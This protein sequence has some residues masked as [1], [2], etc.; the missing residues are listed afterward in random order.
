MQKI[1]RTFS[2]L[3]TMLMI[4]SLLPALSA[5]EE[6]YIGADGVYLVEYYAGG[7]QGTT[8][9]YYNNDYV[10]LRNSTTE[11][12][13]LTGWSLQ[14][15][16]SSAVSCGT[17]AVYVLSG[18]IKANSYYLIIGSGG[19]NVS[20]D[21][22]IGANCEFSNLNISTST[23]KLALVKNSTPLSNL[24][25]ENI[26]T[27]SDIA[28]F[29]GTKGA[30]TQ[31]HL[32]TD[33]APVPTATRCVTR[34]AYTNDNAAD[35]KQ[36]ST[37]EYPILKA[38]ATLGG[39]GG[40]SVA[41][42][43]AIVGW[44]FGVKGIDTEIPTADSAYTQEMNMGQQVH[45]NGTITGGKFYSRGSTTI[46]G[47]SYTT[48]AYGATNWHYENESED[49][50]K[51]FYFSFKTENYKNLAITF[52]AQSSKAGPKYLQVQVKIDGVWMDV[53]GARLTLDTA[54]SGKTMGPIAIN[55]PIWDSAEIIDMRIL[56]VG[57]ESCEEHSEGDEITSTGSLR[58]DDLFI[59]GTPMA[60][61]EVLQDAPGVVTASP[62]P[63]EGS[64]C[65]GTL[66]TLSCETQAATIFYQAG[67]GEYQQIANGSQITIYNGA[68]ITAYGYIESAYGGEV[69]VFDYTIDNSGE[70]MGAC[71]GTGPVVIQEIYGQGGN[72]GSLY[73]TDYIVLRN[74]SEETVSLDGWSLL[75]AS[76]NADFS[77]TQALTK[78]YTFGTGVTIRPHGY[79]LI[80][81]SA[82]VSQVGAYDLQDVDVVAYTE[83]SGSGNYLTLSS[84]GGKLALVKNA[85]VCSG[86]NDP[87]LVDMIG[88]GSPNDY[89]GNGPAPGSSDVLYCI[90]R[91]NDVEEGE[92][93]DPFGGSYTGDN[94]IDF[95][96]AWP[97]PK[98]SMSAG[99]AE[100]YI[101][102]ITSPQSE[103]L[104]GGTAIELECATEGA[105]IYYTTDGGVT[106]SEYTTPIT[107]DQDTLTIRAYATRT[108]NGVTIRGDYYDFSF[109]FLAADGSYT[110][111]QARV[112]QEGTEVTVT[113]TVTFLETNSYGTITTFTMQDETAG[114][115][116]R[117]YANNLEKVEIG[118]I[119]TITG[120]RSSYRGL[121]QIINP[122]VVGSPI[123]SKM[124]TPIEATASQLIDYE[125]AEAH[126]S[127]YVVVRSARMDTINYNEGY[128]GTPPATAIIDDT[129]VV[130][131]HYIPSLDEIV[132][133]DIV[134]VYAVLTQNAQDLITYAD[135]Y[136]LRIANQSWITLIERP[137]EQ[138]DEANIAAWDQ[139]TGSGTNQMLA[140][141]GEYAWRSVVSNG[142]AAGNTYE[143]GTSKSSSNCKG[144]NA[145]GR[146]LQ[147][148]FSTLG[149][150]NVHISA[151]LRSSGAG[152]RNFI[153]QYSFD[154]VT[155]TDIEGSNFSVV[156]NSVNDSL[157]QLLNRYMLPEALWNQETV[158]LRWVLTDNMRADGTGSI[159]SVGSL[160][161]TAVHIS[162][163]ELPS[164]LK[165]V[166]DPASGEVAL[167]SEVALLCVAED[168]TI[169]YRRY[170]APVYEEGEEEGDLVDR[171]EDNWTAF[172][173][174]SGVVLNELPYTLQAYAESATEGEGRVFTFN[175]TQ[176]KCAPIR[177]TAYTGALKAD[178]DVV[179]STATSGAT[180][181][182]A[183]TYN[184]GTA[185]ANTVHTTSA[186]SYTMSFSEEQFPVRVEAYASKDGYLDSETL[187]IDFTLKQTGGE[188]LYFGQ[189]HSHTT[190]SDGVGSIDDAYNYAKNNASNVDFL[191]VTDH[192]HYLDSRSN[193]GTLDGKN[194]GTTTTYIDE[195]GDTVTTTKWDLGRL[196]AEK[197]TDSTFVAD[198][199]YEMTWSGQ[200][201][202]INTY[203]TDGFV[204]RNDG[205]Y[206]VSG[207]TGLVNYYELLTQ[208][209]QSISMFNHPGTTFGTFDDYAYYTEEYDQVITMIEVG[210]GEGAIGSG[211]YWP[212]Y[213]QYTRALDKGW[214]LAPANNQD[215]HKGRWGDANTARDVIW[216]NDFTKNGVLQAMREMRM[217][218]TEDNNL[219][220][221]YF[222]N[223]EPL[224]TI[225]DAQPESLEFDIS[226]YDPDASDKTFTLSIIANNGITV[227]TE[228]GVITGN[229][230]K[231]FN[232]TLEPTYSY[233]YV[234][235]DQS[236][237][238]I[239]VT[240]P[241]WIGE[242]MKVG[243]QSLTMSADYAV[244]GEPLELT[245]VTYNNE[246]VDF[247]IGK[248]SYSIDGGSLI[249]EKNESV[250]LKGG[251]EHTDKISFTPSTAGA[252]TVIAAV[253]GTI[254]G[255]EY[256]FTASLE[257]NV[258][259]PTDILNIAI[260]ASHDNYY[261]SGS[262]AGYYTQLEKIAKSFNGRVTLIQ[263][264]ISEAAL[265][266][267][268]LLI[269]T[270]PYA[271]WSNNGSAYTA[272]ELAAITAY[273]NDGGNLLITG[274]SDRG[275]SST[276][277][278]SMLNEIIEAVGSDT[279][280]RTD[281]VIDLSH[282]SGSSYSV[283]FDSDDNYLYSNRLMA[284]VQAQ[285]TKNF[286]YH[287][288]SSVDAD[289]SASV[290]VRG[291]ST[292]MGTPYSNL[293]TDS[294]YLPL[295]ENNATV[296]G[297]DT[298]L[299]TYEKLSG[300]G[301]MV[302]S[303]MTFFNDYQIPESDY[304]AE[305]QDV[306]YYLTRNIIMSA[307]T[308]TDISEVRQSQVGRWYAVEGTVTT[309]ASG[310]DVNTAFFDSIYIQD[311]TGGIN[312][313]PVS[314]DYAI[315]QKVWACGFVGS[316]QG[317]YQL[318]DVQIYTV[319]SS[320][321][322]IEPTYTTTY[323]S[324]Q[325]ENQGKLIYIE[326]EVES[327]SLNEGAVEYIMVNDG[328]G[329]SRVFIDGYIYCDCQDHDKTA[330]G[331]DMS[332]LKK[333]SKVK[334]IGI[335]STGM[336][337][338]EDGIDQLL[339]RIRIRNRAEITEIESF[340]PGTPPTSPTPTPTPPP[341]SPTPTPTPPP[342]SPTPTP[343]PPP[344]GIL[345]GDAD[346]NG[347]VSSADA[348]AILRYVVMLADLTEQGLINGDVDG[349]AGVD[350]SDA[351]CILRWVVELIH[352]FPVEEN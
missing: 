321:N 267:V 285:S 16:T 326:G 30:S 86:S 173:P 197:Y 119:V 80:Q 342:E 238:N 292:T 52:W 9:N 3:L 183:L 53:P 43:T 57:R 271:G 144:W 289:E 17:D 337:P 11:D 13:D 97:N 192:S 147:F 228:S 194:R 133:G 223:D 273:C 128:G 279:R 191:I 113:G 251:S 212:S 96:L 31:L 235:V 245:S 301:F 39:D 287:S 304:V 278:N 213:E 172:D 184:F 258:L 41:A 127:M 23:N 241:I 165:I 106:Y 263:N 199:G 262:Y 196:T 211:G 178:K 349:E 67:S 24:T 190:L 28:D 276:G 206:T 348:A 63:S 302:V 314:G 320:I 177:S 351:A 82:G 188:Q 334:I 93:A 132:K 102:P 339:P 47:T 346:C 45:F 264:G 307:V 338:D 62:D 76:Q 179:L 169:Y 168:A 108:I 116:V 281:T 153:M 229:E 36:A 8:A 123:L 185:E 134:D 135:G 298:A 284:E 159:S 87:N 81:C 32:G 233:Y 222:I 77:K 193:L 12:V 249:E 315:G 217:Y 2:I 118:K 95:K 237:G 239:A 226:V 21:I 51:G 195:N 69:S 92:E 277:A 208:Y 291:T 202:H 227:H 328:S 163:D 203:A 297:T 299:V 332:W 231:T 242:V 64:V 60:E 61:G 293:D 244:V 83:S 59:S 216:T 56:R 306:N 54:D 214:H 327:V 246:S 344:S 309:N 15:L 33:G 126:E 22:P 29:I 162:G 104:T 141:S 324:M 280:L 255:N 170:I 243:V 5:A 275:D 100:E 261:I 300:G 296:S 335:A 305:Q 333:G 247:N 345:Y 50:G 117:G 10:I 142:D 174:L 20:Q 139:G 176:A 175:Y 115:T 204:S 283:T 72:K 316:Y 94:S 221:T 250:V 129:G 120:T 34:T 248:I 207:G 122:E 167:N 26:P 352:I 103:T 91:T 131:I 101:A 148:E 230:A 138:V 308:T 25:N 19:S 111:E 313:F 265:S 312:L 323:R 73:T 218:A 121:E 181:K 65:A 187:I 318:N 124:P 350:S 27:N 18:T 201:G 260:D 282:S 42:D 171:T 150:T 269:I 224:G 252:I 49:D 180:I 79:L 225:F 270:A 220:V 303:G 37:G 71:V 234:R 85:N 130:N 35:W 266:N 272:A 58:I 112:L 268:D 84:G 46:G 157:K 6:N 322:P 66:V 160:N 14:Y 240:A 109:I 48:Y 290:V 200:Y 74:I 347:D 70:E 4:F 310:H 329:V 90:T 146:Y 75:Y 317:D 182:I 186:D 210:N 209:P 145:E 156:S 140:S 44:T 205:T 256:T 215:N 198:F 340:T 257:I 164:T 331:H 236:D 253:T 88:W 158:Y 105:V 98:N 125:W 99:N 114:I 7:G 232:F 330:T 107:T 149:F 274:K 68:P 319:D 189:I 341:E 254:D 40:V 1:K 78:T 311:A 152:P 166:A 38:L 336:H 288:G 154:G 161:F 343:T 55:L 295:D 110:I 137:V 151:K 143:F 89:L 286:V 325:D 294:P 136:F 259:M 155:F 219:Q